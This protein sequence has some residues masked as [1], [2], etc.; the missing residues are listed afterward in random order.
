MV[1]NYKQL[2]CQERDQ[3]AILRARGRSL[4]EIDKAIGRNPG[5]IS[6]ILA[7]TP[8]MA[9]GA[10]AEDLVSHRGLFGYIYCEKTSLLAQIELFFPKAE[11]LAEEAL[12]EFD[13]LGCAKKTSRSARLSH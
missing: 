2:S 11:F 5:T 3:I 6:K 9:Y 1:T 13:R 7:A 8:G 10:G 4:R 12:K